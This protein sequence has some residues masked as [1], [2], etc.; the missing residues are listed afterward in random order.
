M[1]FA[2]LKKIG[3]E[4]CFAFLLL[5]L[6]IAFN[7]VSILP[8]ATK[9]V[10]PQNDEVLHTVATNDMIG[11]FKAASDPTDFWLPQIAFGYPFFHHYPSLPHITAAISSLLT[12]I[13]VLNIFD[14]IRYLLL[15]LFPLAIFVS[16]R[17]MG[18]GNLAAGIGALAS[19]FFSTSRL[20]GFDYGSYVWS[21]IGLYGQMWAMFFLP[22]AF[23]E[24]YRYL[25]RID[26]SPFLA[27]LL[28][29]IVTLSNAFCMVVLL[30]SLFLVIFFTS[31]KD[32]LL[33]LY[34]GLKFL[35][36]LFLTSAFFF[37]PVF[38]DRKALNNTVWF[39]NFRYDSFGVV[40][41]IKNLFA[42]NLFDYGRLPILTIFFL[43]GLVVLILNFKNVRYRV[44]GSLVLAWFV[45]YFGRPVW[46]WLL[47]LLPFGNEIELD[48]MIIGIHLF[49]IFVI[50]AGLAHLWHYL[51]EKKMKYGIAIRWAVIVLFVIS[52]VPVFIDRIAFYGN[53]AK[54]R[55]ESSVA[56]QNFSPALSDLKNY[57]STQPPGRIYAGLPEGWGNTYY[58]DIGNIPVY[59]LLTGSGLDTLG[60]LYHSFS[61]PADS[62]YL[63]DDSRPA[64]YDL[65]N[66]KYVLLNKTWT[67]PAFYTYMKDFG[68]YNLY[69]VQTSGYFDIV[70]LQNNTATSSEDVFSETKA[71]L[72]SYGPEEKIYE[73]YIQSGSMNPLSVFVPTARP[74][75]VKILDESVGVNV[76]KVD[77]EAD[78]YG[79]LVL[80]ESFHPGW[81]A[82]V[83][84]NDAA[85][86]AVLPGYVGVAVPSGKHEVT[87]T[88]RAFP[89]RWVLI[90][91]GFVTFVILG[92]YW[93]RDSRLDNATEMKSK[94]V[95]SRK[96]RAKML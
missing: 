10:P 59:A 43:V 18:L 80:K 84:G 50:G 13:S 82:T 19:S 95:D 26:R 72:A 76:Y 23:A 79:I 63:F 55:S 96:G 31:L 54:L 94:V 87:I 8:E 35:I 34:R 51:V 65:F 69:S 4:K 40:G 11:A 57:L 68:D 21:G 78:S 46:G 27:V 70:G 58:Y 28:A 81:H 24:G 29:T 33:R 16:M 93:V 74:Q 88:Y 49:A 71:W 1:N 92:F 89:W 6:V 36:L 91:I 2:F 44:V 30:A 14:I 41:V 62:S 90:F 73:P 45:L 83:D 37:I 25:N 85:L 60:Y 38:L 5:F 17:R 12:G 67:P 15:V 56:F 77:Y 32:L 52:L 42:G 47:N 20:L 22:L 7:A 9:S 48:R 53:D 3:G 61:L 75:N 39:Q 64:E 66:V 86:G